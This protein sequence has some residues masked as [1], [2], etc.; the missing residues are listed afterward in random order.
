MFWQHSS[1]F[2]MLA[3]SS[4]KSWISHGNFL[5]LSPLNTNIVLKWVSWRNIWWDQWTELEWSQHWARIISSDN[6]SILSHDP[7]ISGESCMSHWKY[8]NDLVFLGLRS[9]LCSV[10]YD[11]ECVQK[12]C[13]GHN[14]HPRSE[15]CSQQ[16]VLGWS[17]AGSALQWK[18]S[19]DW[20]WL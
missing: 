10:C 2:I 6:S 16:L 4:S 19:G 14:I 12:Q 18:D 7:S 8:L 3:T 17:D 9:Q 20:C 13:C 11:Q 5:Y 1:V 15:R